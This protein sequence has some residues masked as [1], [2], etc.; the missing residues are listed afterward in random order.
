MSGTASGPVPDVGG[1]VAAITS[2]AVEDQPRAA[3]IGSLR[4]GSLGEVC[5]IS[6]ATPAV[7][8]TN[9]RL[10]VATAMI[11]RQRAMIEEACSRQ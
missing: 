6:D 5:G 9:D 7:R 2:R 11:R 8:Q 4:T 3:G 10:E 1:L